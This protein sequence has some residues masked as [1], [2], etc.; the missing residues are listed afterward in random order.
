MLD[1]NLANSEKICFLILTPTPNF[2][3]LATSGQQDMGE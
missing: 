3:A 2:G 1:T